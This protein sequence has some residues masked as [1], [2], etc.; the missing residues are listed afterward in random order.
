MSFLH[1]QILYALPLLLIPVII[2]LVQWKKYKKELFTN[3][4]FLKELEIKSRKSKKLKEMLV[5]LTRIMALLFLILAFA[6]L[7][8]S[9]QKSTPQKKEQSIIYLDNSLSLSLPQKKSNRFFNL[10]M[11]LIEWLEDNKTYHFF[12]NTENF[13]N[14]KGDKLKDHLY[15]QIHLNYKPARHKINLQKGLTGL[16][17]DSSYRP[18]FIYLSDNQNVFNETIDTSLL[19]AN[20]LFLKN[21]FP[22]KKIK[23]ISLDSLI[24]LGKRNRSLSYRLWISATDSS[25]QT[26]VKIR[27]GNRILWSKQIS[28]KDSLRHNLDII[29]PVLPRLNAKVE[30]KDKAFDFDNRLF[31]TYH[32]PEKIKILIVGK[33]IPDFLSKIYTKDEFE[34]VQKNINQVDYSNLN[35]Y[36]LIILYH[37]PII[38]NS[39][40]GFK[41]Y[42]ENYGNLAII[43]DL[44]KSYSPDI[45]KNE[46]KKTGIYLDKLPV[47]DTTTVYLNKINFHSPFFKDIFLKPVKNFSTPR[48]KKHLT[49]RPSRG[50]LY[51]LSDG[52]ALIQKYNSK[53]S[54]YLFSSGL[55]DSGF[56]N[57]AYFIVPVFYQMAKWQQQ[58]NKPYFV[59][60]E[61]TSWSVPLKKVY[62]DEVVRLI[63]E[64]EETIPFQILNKNRIRIKT[65]ES[66]QKPGIYAVV[67][68]KDTLGFAAYNYSR[69]ENTLKTLLWPERKNVAEFDQL[70][71]TIE[72]ITTN[73]TIDITWKYLLLLS[74]LMLLIE[75]LIIKFWK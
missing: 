52:T 16:Q 30:V 71:N 14:I 47:I 34:L 35:Q 11:Q 12:T 3:V 53:G 42:L 65:D 33:E 37:I 44:G 9:K 43:P 41:A 23:N 1:P 66:P 50:W 49:I 61:K 56:Q 58:Q 67:Y 54:L 48:I 40:S 60:G 73:E 46:L 26:P 28:F 2:H 62:Q 32:Q 15:N 74:L 38:Q 18:V 21:K 5:L 8:F 69:I 45:F 72:K 22:S 75:M 70:K 29:L 39:L 51:R 24:F 19:P 59:V 13:S 68:K 17:R 7:N 25:M 36:Q 57:E 63:N 4:N 31:F 64:E 10:K 20:V 55:T 6:G 27:S